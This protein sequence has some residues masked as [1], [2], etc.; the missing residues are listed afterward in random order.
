VCAPLPRVCC[1][2]ESLLPRASKPPGAAGSNIGFKMLSKMGFEQGKGIGKSGDG[3]VAPLNIH[4]RA[5][6]R[7]GLGKEEEVHRLAEEQF[8]RQAAEAN[9]LRSSFLARQ[10]TNFETKQVPPRR[11]CVC[12]YTRVCVCPAVSI[13]LPDHS[14]HDRF[15]GTC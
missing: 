12:V 7:A 6:A 8:Q 4:V 14:R 13:C 2:A 11:M 15:C 10:R 9:E 1:C 5:G 3:A